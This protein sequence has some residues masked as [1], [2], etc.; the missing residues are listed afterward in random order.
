VNHPWAWAFTERTR[1]RS[2]VALRLQEKHWWFGNLNSQPHVL[3]SKISSMDHGKHSQNPILDTS[4]HRLW[5]F[6]PGFTVT[7]PMAAFFTVTVVIPL[8]ILS[9]FLLRNSS[10]L[11]YFGTSDHLFVMTKVWRMQRYFSITSPVPLTTINLFCDY[12]YPRS[13][14]PSERLWSWVLWS[15]H[16]CTCYVWL[17]VA[18]QFTLSDLVVEHIPEFLYYVHHDHHHL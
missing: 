8:D 3:A 10:T 15:K 6:S 2:L 18:D 12:H 17:Y 13:A 16:L 7:L 9:R 4:L 11:H 1:G 5:L 14:G